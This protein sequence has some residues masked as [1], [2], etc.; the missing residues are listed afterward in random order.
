MAAKDYLDGRHEGHTVLYRYDQ[1][2]NHAI[3]PVKFLWQ[4]RLEVTQSA[5][6][7]SS[8]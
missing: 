7:W 3:G 6:H 5:D 2:P 4:S 1:C 8:N